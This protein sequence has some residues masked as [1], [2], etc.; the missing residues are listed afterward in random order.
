MMAG[1]KQATLRNR[2]ELKGIGV[3]S[4]VPVRIVLHPADIDTGIVFLRTRIEGGHER[5]IEARHSFDRKAWFARA[6][7]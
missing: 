5:L 4:G 1:Q 3:H 7:A 2:A 6:G